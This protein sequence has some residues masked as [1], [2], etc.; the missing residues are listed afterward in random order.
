[1]SN[2]YFYNRVKRRTQVMRHC[3]A[4]AQARAE[5]GPPLHMNGSPF[6]SIFIPNLYIILFLM[7]IPILQNSERMAKK[8]LSSCRSWKEEEFLYL[9][10]ALYYRFKI[11]W[12]FFI[13]ILSSLLKVQNILHSCVQSFVEWET[14]PLLDSKLITITENS[15]QYSHCLLI[16]DKY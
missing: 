4:T 6:L 8:R 3:R 1:M 12:I 11:Q 2:I 9:F 7:F 5:A 10:V 16:S 14:Q 13:E 15:G